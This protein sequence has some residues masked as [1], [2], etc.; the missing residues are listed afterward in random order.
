M[1]KFCFRFIKR[2]T[3]F[4]IFL[5]DPQTSPASRRQRPLPPQI[6]FFCYCASSPSCLV[7]PVLSVFK[8]YAICVVPQRV[9]QTLAESLAAVPPSAS[10]RDRERKR[11]GGNKAKRNC[12]KPKR[13]LRKG[14]VGI[15]STSC[16]YQRYAMSSFQAPFF[17]SGFVSYVDR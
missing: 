15:A 11:Q 16:S 9:A 13:K 14:V 5:S 7:R 1:G 3:I 8:I 2:Q 17:K 10:T 12:C 6:S 4:A